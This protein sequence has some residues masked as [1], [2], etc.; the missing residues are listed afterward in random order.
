MNSKIERMDPPKPWPNR[1]GKFTYRPNPDTYDEYMDKIIAV[2]KSIDDLGKI[3]MMTTKRYIGM[4]QAMKDQFFLIA[5][6]LHDNIEGN[7]FFK[8]SDWDK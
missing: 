5:E 1:P 4:L 7:P 6:N 3:D 2:E 8:Q